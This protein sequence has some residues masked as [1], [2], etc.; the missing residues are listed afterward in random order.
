MV[1]CNIN[2]SSLLKRC[3]FIP[4]ILSLTW[5]FIVQFYLHIYIIFK[6]Q[7]YKTD[8]KGQIHTKLTKTKQEQNRN[9]I[10]TEQKQ[11]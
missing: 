11:N 10:K 5:Q 7:F 6:Y 4:Q 3:L 2:N 1:C 9:K 8:I